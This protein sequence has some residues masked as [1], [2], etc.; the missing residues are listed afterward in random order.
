MIY[1][2]LERSVA[3]GNPV[4]LYRFAQGTNRWLYTSGCLPIS[5]LSETYQPLTIARG[6]IEQA[7]DIHRNGIDVTLPRDC[8]VAGLFI[9]APPEGIVSFTLYRKHA[10]DNEFITYWKGRVSAARFGGSALQL[11]CEPIATSLK[12][13]GLRARYQLLC[14]HVLYSASC[15]A[16]RESYRSDDNVTAISGAQI[17][18]PVAAGKADG[19][20][21]AGML[22]SPAGLRM[23]TAHVGSTITLI[24]PLVGLRQGDAVSL[25]AGCDHSSSQCA[26]RFSNLDNYGGFPFIPV[27]NPF[28]GDAIV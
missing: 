10:S 27:K 9:A 3:D 17:T 28:A 19:Y 15:G 24:V 20:F 2:T 12:R 5:Y 21:T 14:R 4:E 13:V 8:P 26:A 25:F 23:I 16:L 6:A 18:V 11:K 1:T 7:N 22:L